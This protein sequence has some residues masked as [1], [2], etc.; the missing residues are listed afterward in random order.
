MS[1]GTYRPLNADRHLVAAYATDEALDYARDR[2]IG[3]TARAILPTYDAM[4]RVATGARDAYRGS[5]LFR[6]RGAT[7]YAKVG[8]DWFHSIAD[9]QRA[10]AQIST[11]FQ[12]FTNDLASWIP[13]HDAAAAQWVDASV[14]LTLKEW[15]T[16][17][18]HE[19][20]SWWVK[21]ATNWTAFE[22]WQERLKRLR[23]LARA[24]G[25]VLSSAEPVDLP[26]TVWEQGAN[27][28]GNQVASILGVLK[29]AAVGALAITGAMTLLSGL[30]DLRGLHDTKA[31]R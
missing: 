19:S 7:P 1:R 28:E 3:T 17:A 23:E 21:A 2:T 13:G 5:K 12:T 24:H 22:E 29:V 20:S 14:T 10:V 18:A 8:S 30:R 27:G 26:R 6:D 4:S 9:R 25:I 15:A 31:G 16:F 11:D